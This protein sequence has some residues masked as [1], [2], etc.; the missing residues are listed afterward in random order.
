MYLPPAWLLKTAPVTPTWSPTSV[1]PKL[2]NWAF[3]KKVGILKMKYKI[4][5][6]QLPLSEVKNEKYFLVLPIYQLFGYNQGK[7]QHNFFWQHCN[8]TAQKKYVIMK[9]C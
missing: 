1:L 5:Y 2:L 3:L 8:Q 7:I 9:H 6:S 4:L